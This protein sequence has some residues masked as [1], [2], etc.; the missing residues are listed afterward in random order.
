ML[1]PQFVVPHASSIPQNDAGII[2]GLIENP[3]NQL[4]MFDEADIS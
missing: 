1:W 3:C 2:S 4:S